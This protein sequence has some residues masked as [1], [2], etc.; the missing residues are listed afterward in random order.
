MNSII[1][2]YRFTFTTTYRYNVAVYSKYE[3]HSHTKLFVKRK[4]KEGADDILNRVVSSFDRYDMIKTKI[5]L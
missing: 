4:D 5:M 3:I 1:L 2:I